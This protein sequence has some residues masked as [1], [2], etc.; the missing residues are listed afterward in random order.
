MP[1]QPEFPVSYSS[2]W[3]EKLDGRTILARAVHQRYAALTDDLGGVDA[4]SYQRR[5]LAKRAIYIEA[6]IERHEAALSRGEDV[7]M[8]RLTQATNSLIGL[9]KAL[10]L[11]RKARD[12]SLTDYIKAR[13]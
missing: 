6:V 5:S 12:V 10:G 2:D 8:G 3:L 1:K 4:L 11:E 9:L 7:D 13:S